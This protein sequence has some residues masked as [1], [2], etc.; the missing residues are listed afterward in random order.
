MPRTTAYDAIVRI[1]WFMGAVLQAGNH[2]AWL[3]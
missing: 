2:R 3:C 1:W